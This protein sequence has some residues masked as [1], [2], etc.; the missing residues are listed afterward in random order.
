MTKLSNSKKLYEYAQNFVIRGVHTNFKYIYPHPIYFSKAEG[1]K[2]WDVDGNEYID[3]VLNFGPLI[4]GHRHPKVVQAV[5]DQLE[6]GLTVGLPTERSVEV[7]KKLLDM[8]PSAET[9]RLGNTGT[10]AVMHALKIARAYT[11]RNKILKIEGGYNGHCDDV[12]VSHHPP[13][14]LAGP[15]TSPN[16]VPDSGGLRKGVTEDTIVIPFNNQEVAEKVVKENKK[17]VAALIIEPIQFN[18]GCVL[19][20]EGYLQAIRE[21]TERTNIVLIFDEVRSGFRPAPG[22]A[23]EYYGVDPDLTIVAKAIAN[24]F[25]LS[26]LLGKKDV[27]DVT[28]PVTGGVLY[29]GTYNANQMSVA[30]ASA[31]LEQLRKGDVQ[32]YLNKTCQK[33]VSRFREVAED[34][35]VQAM[36][37]ALGGFFQI[38]FT[39]Q[40]PSDYRTAL[41]ADR[42]KFLKLQDVMINEGIYCWPDHL[43]PHGISAAHDKEDLQKISKTI[44]MGISKIVE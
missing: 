4:L 31:T 11:G 13:L 23:Q 39:E 29:A 24:G 15:K 17:E 19:P 8:M 26:A 1:S 10:E 41:L 42:A 18:L 7:S 2:I 34:N 12:L 30:A 38:Y 27:M 6:T 22:G 35:K 33:L 43:F 36:M 3:C 28:D 14:K 21:M 5:K 40:A 20:K 37:Q 9:V 44:E 32:K 25:P 16:A